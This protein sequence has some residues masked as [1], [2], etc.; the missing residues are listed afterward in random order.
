ME[1]TVVCPHCHSGCKYK[2][3]AALKLA[4]E[5]SIN[6]A[7][8]LQLPEAELVPTLVDNNYFHFVLASDNILAASVVAKSLV[9]N[10]LRPH[11]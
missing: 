3:T 11:N 9:Q 5:H 6:A 4:N 10:S 8:R 1:V 7:A 2:G